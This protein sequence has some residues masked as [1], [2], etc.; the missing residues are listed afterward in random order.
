MRKKK[1]TK[2]L[3]VLL[4]AGMLTQ[5][6]P[7]SVLAE[8]VE[9]S[10][11]ASMSGTESNT[12]KV[13]ATEAGNTSTVG[14]ENGHRTPQQKTHLMWEIPRTPTQLRVT[15]RIRSRVSN[16]HRSRIQ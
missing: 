7:L 12:G 16:A 6:M 10:Y 3:A 1:L 13:S 14:G 8:N 11:E 15:L 5:T 4:T 2:T 9:A